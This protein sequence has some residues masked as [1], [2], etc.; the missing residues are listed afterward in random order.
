MTGPRTA[1]TWLSIGGVAMVALTAAGLYCESHDRMPWYFNVVPDDLPWFI[2]AALAQGIIYLGA[3]L[4]VLRRER[5][6]YALAVILG[7]AAIARLPVVL[8]TPYLSNDA[9][10]YIW[11]GRVQ[12]RGINPYRFAPS[13]PHLTA[14]RD[15]AVYNNINRREYARTI[16]P[17]VAEML[18]FA[19]TRASESIVWMK[20]AMVA[21]EALAV[22]LL[23]RL[24][25]GLRLSPEH[26]IIYAWNP[27]A[28]WEFA[29]SGHVDA[30]A[31]AFI[32]LALLARHRERPFLTGFG[33]GCATMIKLYPALLFPALYRRWDW[34]MP[35]AFVATV[36]GSYA[37]YLG[38]GTRVIG[39]LPVYLKEEG[40]ING[41]RFY[42]TELL[43]IGL[44]LQWLSPM[45]CLV[46]VGLLL[47]AV[48][49]FVFVRSLN[50]HRGWLVGAVTMTTTFSILFSPHNPWYFAWILPILCALPYAPMIYLVTASPLLYVTLMDGS[51]GMLLRINTLLYLSFAMFVLFDLAARRWRGER[52]G[53]IRWM[54]RFEKRDGYVFRG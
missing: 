35:A 54:R 43:R 12:A 50:G 20:T 46:A 53:V 47:A 22:W 34:K 29:G 25:I 27:I 39:F 10:R 7:V 49:A 11:D 32:A 3:V 14:L 13:D 17:P 51:A 2:A 9:Y 28:L 24:L 37:P 38:V 33:L 44:K 45:R 48:T 41:T 16:Y 42:L 40:L 23:I 21:F 36:L 52:F 5:G 4:L 30:A 26:V 1:L 15:A 8:S 18:F 6:R 19:I 31:V